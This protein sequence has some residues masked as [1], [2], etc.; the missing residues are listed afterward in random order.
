MPPA[1][2]TS[3]LTRDV[4][5]LA[6]LFLTSGATHLVRPQ[7]FEPIVPRALPARRGLVYAS[8]LAEILCAA[9]LLV[10]RTRV[11]AG[12]AS[13]ALLVAVF[14]ANVQMSLDA[15]RRATRRRDL[16]SAALLGGTLARLPLQWPMVRAALRSASRP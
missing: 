16:A 11:A 5:A 9:G 2:G 1:S 3:P 15:A 14:P 7:V 8:G 4:V 13:A 6:A 10:P 12:W